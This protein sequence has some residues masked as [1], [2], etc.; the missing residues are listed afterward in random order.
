MSKAVAAEGV[1]SSE[2]RGLLVLLLTQLCVGKIKIGDK[3]VLL[4]AEALLVDHLLAALGTGIGLSGGVVLNLCCAQEKKRRRC[5]SGTRNRDNACIKNE[6]TERLSVS[7]HLFF[8]GC[9][10]A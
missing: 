9:F 1:G 2:G 8:F 3:M 10:C 7:A 4:L 6:K 5:W